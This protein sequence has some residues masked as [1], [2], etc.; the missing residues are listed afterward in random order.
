MIRQATAK[1]LPEVIGLVKKSLEE[2]G[3]E[4][5]EALITKKVVNSFHLAPCFLLVKYDIIVG[6]VGYTILTNSWSGDATLSDYMFYV[7]KEHR[8][9][10]TLSDLIEHSKAFASQNNLPLRIETIANNDEEL[11]KR[12]F[13]MHGFNV[14]S[15]VGVFK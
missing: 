1:D 14:Y 9:I 12:L 7:E 2:M 10:R 15:V 13:R 5:N 8:N 4:V 11:R 6:M 3:E